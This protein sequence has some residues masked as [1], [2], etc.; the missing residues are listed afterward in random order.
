MLKSGHCDASRPE[1]CIT[2]DFISCR[3]V[4]KLV[5]VCKGA[6]DTMAVTLQDSRCAQ[7]VCHRSSRV[8]HQRPCLCLREARVAGGVGGSDT[9]LLAAWVAQF[10]QTMCRY[11]RRQREDSIPFAKAETHESWGCGRNRLGSGLGFGTA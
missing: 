11:R 1:S 2:T 8:L 6:P 3:T 10:A 4:S 7:P 5:H 9:G